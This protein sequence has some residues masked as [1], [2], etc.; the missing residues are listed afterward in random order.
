MIITEKYVLGDL[1]FLFCSSDE[2]LYA[3]KQY[4][5]HN[6]LTDIITFDLSDNDSIIDGDILICTD[7]VRSNSAHYKTSFDQELHRVIFHGVL[8]LC[9]YG[10]KASKEIELMRS[11]EDF[12]LAQYFPE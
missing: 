4:L 11:K 2:I 8:H 10:D 3:N 5:A 9:G 12:Y 1:N 6:Y 7:V